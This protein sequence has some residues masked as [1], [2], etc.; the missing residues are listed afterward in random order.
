[1]ARKSVAVVLVVCTMDKAPINIEMYMRLAK[2]GEY[3]TFA[4]IMN[5]CAHHKHGL[6]KHTSYI[7]V[8]FTLAMGAGPPYI[9]VGL[10]R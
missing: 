3:H 4:C 8:V 5:C 6:Y 2:L 10:Q 1:M 9:S 7:N